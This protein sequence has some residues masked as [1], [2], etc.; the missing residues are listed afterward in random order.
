[1]KYFEG[2]KIGSYN[3][4]LIKR[5]P[6]SRA[7]FRCGFCD[8]IF[9][10]KIS[11]IV[12]G[13]TSSCGCNRFKFK[14]GDKLGPYETIFLNRKEDDHKKGLFKC[15][16][17]GEIFENRIGDISNG[18]V[19]SCGCQHYDNLINKR[20][21]KLTVIEKTEQRSGTSIV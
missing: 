13:S 2:N 14:S 6:K 21:N 15:S 17:C 5:L 4:L 20:F 16:F 12:D 9:E 10:S 8:K 7:I 3:T 19:K 11:H 1:M 18:I